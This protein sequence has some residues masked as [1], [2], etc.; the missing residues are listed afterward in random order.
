MVNLT[1]ENASRK[2]DGLGRI[3]IP[4]NLR[5]RYNLAPND[6]VF[7]YSLDFENEKYLC[8]LP[9]KTVDPRYLTTLN[10]L[11]ELGLA[12]PRELEEKI[13]NN[14]TTSNDV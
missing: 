11:K 8:L 13:N 4:S 1:N 6:E 7:F 10:V 3:V 9:A 14:N 2:M 12:V 5:A